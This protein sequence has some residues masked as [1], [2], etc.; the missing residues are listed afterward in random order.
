MKYDRKVRLEGAHYKFCGVSSS[1]DTMVVTTVSIS[2]ILRGWATK[3]FKNG[4]KY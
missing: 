2:L 3:V 1:E 4:D